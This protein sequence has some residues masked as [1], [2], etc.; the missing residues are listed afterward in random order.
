MTFLTLQFPKLLTIGLLSLI[1]SLSTIVVST[2][3][4]AQAT[5]LISATVPIL[6]GKYWIGGTDE[7]MEIK[8]DRYRYYNVG[9]EREWRSTRE[10]TAI[11]EGVVFDG[12][13]YW[14]L[15]TMKSKGGQISCSENGWDAKPIVS[16]TSNQ[17]INDFIPQGWQIE[18]DISGDLNNDGQADRVI[19]IAEAGEARNQQRSLLLLQST[20]TGWNQIATAPKLLLCSSCAGMMGTTNG[21]HIRLTI[22]DGILIVDQFSGSRA[23]LSITHRFWIDENSQ[24]VV[25]IG[26][27]LSLFDRILNNNINDSRNFLT[28]KR[29]VNEYRRD[30]K[31]PFTRSQTF[32]VSRELS[33]IE[34][35]DI[36]AVK[37]SAPKFP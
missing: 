18:Q 6:N 4:N 7:S 20:A 13:L 31:K 3:P 1:A 25:L 15:S 35:I 8:G 22:K 17:S 36:E 5:V 27:D 33:T 12:K 30:G 10:L 11:K 21:T 14:C 26:E 23:I 2:L 29:I 37:Q 24:K 28:G 16:S 32:K 9:G 19:Q 34:S